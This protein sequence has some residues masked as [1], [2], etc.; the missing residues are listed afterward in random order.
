MR[1]A[2]E[3]LR[4]V[5]QDEID[6]E[7]LPIHRAQIADLRGDVAAQHVYGD[8][9]ADLHAETVGDFLLQ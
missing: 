6:A 4:R 5:Y 9:V 8:V 3:G 2:G 1:G 7:A